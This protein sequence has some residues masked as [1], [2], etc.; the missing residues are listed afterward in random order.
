MSDLSFLLISLST[1]FTCQSY[2]LVSAFKSD[3]EYRFSFK[4]MIPYKA[5]PQL[6]IFSLILCDFV[7]CV[8]FLSA[9]GSQSYSYC[10]RLVACRPRL[11]LSRCGRIVTHAHKQLKNTACTLSMCVFMCQPHTCFGYPLPNTH[12][13]SLSILWSPSVSSPLHVFHLLS[14]LPHSQLYYS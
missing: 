9:R 2:Q 5:E 6:L 4:N 3:N 14:L 12:S 7:V 11:P 8:C 13:F 10:V 1:V